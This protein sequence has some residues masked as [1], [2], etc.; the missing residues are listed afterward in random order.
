MQKLLTYFMLLCATLLLT[1]FSWGF[2]SDDPCRNALELAGTL[3]GIR[4]E[5]QARQTEARILSLCPDGGAGHYVSAIQLERVGNLDGAI[6]EYRKALQQEK[7]FALASGNLGLLYAQKGMNDEASVEL[8]RGLASH[9]SPRYHKAMARIL[10]DRKVYPLAIYH[11]TE[12]ARELTRDVAVFNGLAEAYAASGQPDKALEEYRRALLADP[13]SEAS[14]IGI[15]AI[16]L[17]RNEQDKAL[18]SL[19]KA[20]TSNPQNREIHLMM[21]AIYEKKGDAKSAEYQYL[22]GGKPKTAA[23]SA[24]QQKQ[25]GD[26][27]LSADLAR[28]IDSIQTAIK[29]NP[30][31]AILYEKLGNQ[32]RSVG[33]DTEAIAAYREAAHLNSL[34]HEVYLNLGILLEKRSQLDEAVVAYKQALRIKPDS[35]DAHLRLADLRNSRGLYQEAVTHYGEFLKLKPDSP[36]IQLKLAR[37]FARNKENGLAIDAYIAFLKHSPDNV[38]ANREIAA[39]YRAKG[40]NDKAV[41]HYT[42]VLAKQKDDMDTRNALVSI[43]VKNKQYDEI[44]V[45]LKGTAELFPDDPNNHYK[46]GLIY[47]FKKDYESAIAGYK[48]AVEVKADHARSLNALGRL[49]MKTGRIDEAKV[50]LEAA[51]KADPTL[52]ETTVLLNNIRDEFN[53]EPRKITK[54]KKSKSK[55]SRK[56]SKGKKTAKSA[57][58]SDKKPAAKNKQP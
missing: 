35:A 31:S 50:V 24:L 33:K 19:K 1:G 57:K 18:E 4:D 21:A 14:H 47:E 11:Y 25:S 26:D 43:Y 56:S 30:T 49:Y 22:L 38:E 45:L 55:K 12:A 27:P 48:K 44:T 39:L 10:A 7:S 3:E 6:G 37:I 51:K 53:P 52:E 36:D 46:L 41:E 17:A 2:G 29:K 8:A 34:N 54:G 16:H 13:D 58:S 42:R 40:T 32:Y 15:A 5:V 9:P 23:G 20:E 28:D